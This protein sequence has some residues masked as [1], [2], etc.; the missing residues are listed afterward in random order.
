VATWPVMDTSAA[1]PFLYILQVLSAS[2]LIVLKLQSSWGLVAM[3]DGGNL[4][5]FGGEGEPS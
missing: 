4:K 3:L 1:S 2:P 5:E